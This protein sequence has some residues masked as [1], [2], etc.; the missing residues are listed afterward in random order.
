MLL[1]N[2][3]FAFASLQVILILNNCD[4]QVY[5]LLENCG[6]QG[7]ACHV[8]NFVFTKKILYICSDFAMA[9]LTLTF[10]FPWDTIAIQYNT[11]QYNYLT[12]KINSQETLPFQYDEESLRCC[13]TQSCWRKHHCDACPCLWPVLASASLWILKY[14]FTDFTYPW[15]FQ[16][17]SDLL[18]W[19]FSNAKWKPFL[20]SDR[21][22]S[23]VSIPISV[24][25][26]SKIH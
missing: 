5:Y 10:F 3:Q 7:V 1:D 2:P 8:L 15:L 25:D 20:W 19:S 23:K 17:V 26:I 22:T 12:Q 11:I 6:V 16:A 13:P 18:A 14:F 9:I 21:W 24:T 4:S